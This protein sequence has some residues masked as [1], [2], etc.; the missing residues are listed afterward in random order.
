LWQTS[1]L[2]GDYTT[3]PKYLPKDIGGCWAKKLAVF[4]MHKQHKQVRTEESGLS[5]S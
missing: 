3:I 5:L 1:A 4:K 2:Y